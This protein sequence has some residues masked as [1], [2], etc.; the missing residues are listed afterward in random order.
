MAIRVLIIAVKKQEHFISYLQSVVYFNLNIIITSRP[1]NF[2][3]NSVAI[4]NSI[5]TAIALED[6]DFIIQALAN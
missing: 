4:L 2:I 3:A 6:Y 5:A 1:F